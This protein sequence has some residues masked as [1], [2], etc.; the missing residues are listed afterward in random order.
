MLD[1]K[2]VD[3]KDALDAGRKA[4]GSARDELKRQL[5]DAREARREEE[6]EEFEDEEAEGR[7]RTH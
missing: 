1:D 5:A 6:S 4:V 3:A 2:R 7:G